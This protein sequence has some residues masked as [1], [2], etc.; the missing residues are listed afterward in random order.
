MPTCSISNR[1]I[2]TSKTLIGI[3]ATS[4]CVALVLA[5]L[6]ICRTIPAGT[7][8]IVALSFAASLSLIS[9]VLG[10][11]LV[12]RNKQEESARG[13]Q[14]ASR[15]TDDNW[16][17]A[18]QAIELLKAAP[19][20]SSL[21]ELRGV[22][23]PVLVKQYHLRAYYR[24]I[25]E[26]AESGEKEEALQEI[27]HL[28]ALWGHFNTAIEVAQK[29]SDRE[30]QL[31]T[32]ID[33][34]HQMRLK[35]KEAQ[36]AA[37][38]NSAPL[39]E[40]CRDLPG[41]KLWY[42][43]I[44]TKAKHH[45]AQ[46]EIT[47]ALYILPAQ[48]I[49]ADFTWDEKWDKFRREV[50]EFLLELHG[51]ALTGAEDKEAICRLLKIYMLD[52]SSRPDEPGV[53][54][55]AFTMVASAFIEDGVGKRWN[56]AAFI[57]EVVSKCISNLEDFLFCDA[58]CHCIRIFIDKGNFTRA[59]EL[60]S[61][62]K[63]SYRLYADFL[64]KKGRIMQ[65]STIAERVQLLAEETRLEDPKE[66]L[67]P[68]EKGEGIVLKKGREE[69]RDMSIYTQLFW[70]QMYA[71]RALRVLRNIVKLQEA[72]VQFFLQFERMKLCESIAPDSNKGFQLQRH[73]FR[74]ALQ[75]GDE[76]PFALM[77][78]A[79]Y[80]ME[81]GYHERARVLL[82]RVALL[83]KSDITCHPRLGRKIREEL[84]YLY[85]KLGAYD[86]ALELSGRDGFRGYLEALRP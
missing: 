75:C 19:E 78:L 71:A 67:P 58:L 86:R 60:R 9:L 26:Q 76:A 79:E 16:K 11:V 65:A 44:L 69:F 33:I 68:D 12:R 73:L 20:E 13:A 43:E 10:V 51:M 14:Q 22:N 80:E 34:M 24:H 40:L 17:A 62:L 81:T 64:I 23:D 61:R 84:S 83:I 39:E 70:P 77:R 55:S 30:M 15:S 74:L 82:E 7:N 21:T 18:L 4:A 3:A 32:G 8:A 72:C 85:A 42:R 52:I 37:Y 46:G 47:T 41:S 38:L 59:E 53:V 56:D 29:I 49:K 50:V 2:F 54:A 63:G 57:E 28:F 1:E 45:A 66:W 48:I 36:V 25:C 6:V 27:A 5:I 35:G 31:I